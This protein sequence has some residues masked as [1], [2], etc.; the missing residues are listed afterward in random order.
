MAKSRSRAKL[1]NCFNEEDSALPRY[2]RKFEQN[3]II[4]I[5]SILQ[6]LF[7]KH[8]FSF[9]IPHLIKIK[10]INFP[11]RLKQNVCLKTT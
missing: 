4:E 11:L 8:V 5:I 1:C 3:V 9:R 10:D 2:F 6:T 7:C